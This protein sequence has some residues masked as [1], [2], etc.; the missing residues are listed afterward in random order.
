MTWVKICG[1]TNLEDALLAVDA[2]A[3]AVGFVFYEKSARCIGSDAAKEIVE[4][5]PEHVEK[6]GVFVDYESGAIQETVRKVGLTAVQLHGERSLR[7]VWGSEGQIQETARAAKLIPV[8][9]G[10]VL[11]HGEFFIANPERVFAIMLDA[12]ANGKM[13][14]TGT[15]FDWKAK[16]D[17]VQSIGIM[18]PT[19]VAGGL[20][21]ANVTEAI[22]VLM[23]WGV[24]VVSGVEVRPGKKDPAKV[25]AFVQAVRKVERK[26]S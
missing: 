20:T 6:V 25:R 10:D 15:T 7:S 18:F 19:I 24:D 12:Q 8:F 23:P 11:E 13:G 2:G 4:K 16:H 14:G 5:L 3:D 9:A 17:V 21:A 22:S 26:A 1:T